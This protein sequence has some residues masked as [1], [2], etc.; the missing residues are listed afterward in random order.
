MYPVF[1][2]VRVSG[3][4]KTAQIRL[5]GLRGCRRGNEARF[6]ARDESEKAPICSS[7]VT[8]RASLQLLHSAPVR[9]GCRQMVPIAGSYPPP[10]PVRIDFAPVLGKSGAGCRAKWNQRQRQFLPINLRLSDFSFRAGNCWQRRVLASWNN[11]GVIKS[12]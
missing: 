8:S 4:H 9:F 11:K 5:A 12:Q 7:G 10:P 1:E 3:G 2:H 6:S